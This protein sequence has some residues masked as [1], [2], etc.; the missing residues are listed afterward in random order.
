MFGSSR[1]TTI[2]MAQRIRTGTTVQITSRRVCPCT[3]A[4]S[5]VRFRPRDRYLATKRT[6]AP[7]TSTKMAA[8]KPKITSYAV[9]V[10]AAFGEWGVTGKKPPSAAEATCADSSAENA[11][12]AKNVSFRRKPQAFYGGARA[13][14]CRPAALG[15]LRLRGVRQR[16]PPGSWR[17]LR[18]GR[19]VARVSP[20]GRPGGPARPL[21][22]AVDVARDRRHVPAARDR[23]RRVRVRRPPRRRHRPEAGGLRRLLGGHQLRRAAVAREAEELE[24]GF[25]VHV[26]GVEGVVRAEVDRAV[27]LG[28]DEAVVGGEQV[29]ADEVAANGGGSRERQRSCEC[30][31]RD[32]LAPS[33]ERDVRAPLAWRR[34]STSRTDD[35]PARD[36]DA[37]VPAEGRHELL[38]ERAVLAE[39]SAQRGALERCI[40]LGGGAAA[41][42]VASPAAEAW[43]QDERQLGRGR[44]HAFGD[45][46]RGRMRKL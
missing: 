31:R 17:R 28:D 1:K 11:T 25:D 41:H 30:G 23:R 32:R 46:P 2:P 20:P 7:S 14:A 45:Q 34:D 33:A 19:P 44:R 16:G 39:P 37:Q 24:H 12:S 6:S 27:Q 40:E 22:V 10:C 13:Y 4:P 9:F 36:D 42:D 18:G 29:D 43:L 38:R 5:S 26:L 35:A 3:C 15:S 8:V 21:A